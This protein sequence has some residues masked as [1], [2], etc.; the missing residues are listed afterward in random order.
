[1]EYLYPVG[2]CVLA[3]ALAVYGGRLFRR[4]EKAAPKDEPLDVK[5]T[6]ELLLDVASYLN[7]DASAGGRSYRWKLEIEANRLKGGK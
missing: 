1:M 6:I 2:W 4:S 3:I 7:A 5:P